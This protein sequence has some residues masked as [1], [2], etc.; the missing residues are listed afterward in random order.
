MSDSLVRTAARP[1]GA[2]LRVG[3]LGFG[4]WRLVAMS[5]AEARSRIE[6]AL[7]SGM[8]LIDTADVYGL[9]W[10]GEGFGGAEKLLGRVLSDAPALRERMVLATKGGIRPPVPYDSSAASLVA[11]CEASLGRL[12]V[13][14]VDLY[15]IHRPDLYAHPA[16][17]AE[18][19]ARLRE[20]GKI[21]EAGVSNHTPAQVD[22]LAAH[23]PF[24]LAST[25]PE[26]S[27][28]RLA[29]MR[30]G[31]FDQCL[32][33]SITAL[34][35][36]PL[37]GGRV[38]TGEGLSHD[39]VS[40]LDRFAERE[41][42]D[43]AALA[44]AFVLAHPVAPVAIVGSMAPERIRAATAALGVRLDR[45]DVYAIFQAAEGAHLP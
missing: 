43:R 32:R 8:N 37:A 29:P 14:C 35:W 42:V 30:D 15:Q 18:A 39:L 10:G 1:L 13:E 28:A 45:A 4:C 38:P 9:D 34:A 11:A 20:A 24:P 16:E 12:R 36:G 7:D 2:E 23:L 33:L 44:L 27:V 31:T 21:R 41:G 3:P 26:F 5:P 22:A 19:L 6:A 25:Q 40:T 17:V